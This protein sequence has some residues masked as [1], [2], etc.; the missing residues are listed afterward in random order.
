[1]SVWRPS[2]QIAVKALGLVWREGLLLASEIYRDDGSIKGVRP[3]GGHIEFGETWQAALLREFREELQVD[4][5]VRGAPLV[6]ENLYT[7]HGVQGHEVTFVAEVILP[8]E[9]YPGTD[10]IIYR[11]DQ[12]QLQRADWFDVAM[13]DQGG[14]E[15]YPNGL[16]SALA[17]HG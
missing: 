15:L 7:H 17:V 3:L 1:M 5:A 2:Q 8:Q 13:L 6:L 16:K 10:P 4:V 9:T 14:L 12:G 11:E